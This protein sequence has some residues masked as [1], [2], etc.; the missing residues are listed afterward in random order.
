MHHDIIYLYSFLSRI[1]LLSI[2]LSIYLSQVTFGLITAVV[3]AE[4]GSGSTSK[5]KLGGSV[6]DRFKPIRNDYRKYLNERMY[7]LELQPSSFKK[8]AAMIGHIEA[9]SMLAVSGFIINY[10]PWIVVFVWTVC[11]IVCLIEGWQDQYSPLY[12]TGQTWLGVCVT[13]TYL[14]FGVT[15]EKDKCKDK[16]ENDERGNAKDD[17][18]EEVADNK[19]KASMKLQ[20]ED[21]V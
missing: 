11:G 19:L 6:Y 8:K 17:E 12:T 4:I 20:M 3:V 15:E 9:R 10:S 13:T 7:D 16:C 21:A 1:P 5:D 14:Y 2:Y 18:S